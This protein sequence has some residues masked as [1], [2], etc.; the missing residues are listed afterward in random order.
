MSLP[1]TPTDGTGTVPDDSIKP[2][3]TP[4]LRINNK[5]R[6]YFSDGTSQEGTYQGIYNHAWH[7]A[8]QALMV[9]IIDTKKY[10]HSSHLY[11]PL[12]QVK[13]IR[14]LET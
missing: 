9:K 14:V 11:I 3:T 8:H 6:I 5:V 7:E 13:W 4:E 10:P 12:S 1:P 2:K